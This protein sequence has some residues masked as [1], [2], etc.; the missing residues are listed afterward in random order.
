M[1]LFYQWLEAFQNILPP[2]PPPPNPKRKAELTYDDL[3]KTAQELGISVVDL[4]KGDNFAST[5]NRPPDP[6]IL[7]NKLKL[8]QKMAEIQKRYQLDMEKWKNRR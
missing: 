2:P 8:R 3:N 5:S 7:A 4:I 1:K 6:S